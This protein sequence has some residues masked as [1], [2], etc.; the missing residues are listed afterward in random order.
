MKTSTIGWVAMVLT[1]AGVATQ[2]LLP[3]YLRFSFV[4]FLGA[5][6]LWLANGIRTGNRP[7]MALQL[8]TG[9]LNVHAV[10]RYFL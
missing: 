1:L 6:A 7:L 8:V 4:V 9:L 3:V 10:M 2:S 5:N